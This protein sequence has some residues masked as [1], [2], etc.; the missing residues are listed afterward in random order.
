MSKLNI[1]K[2]H[3]DKSPVTSK[4]LAKLIDII[5]SGRISGKIAK[6]IFY[7]MYKTSVDP[8]TLIDKMNITQI[9]DK[10]IIITLCNEAIKEN[11]KAALEFQS[12]KLKA[13][14]SIV[15]IVMK[16]SKGKANPQLVIEVINEQLKKK[17]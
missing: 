5:I 7:E 11:I 9:S 3:I 8:I 10:S 17:K 15:G 16:K 12:G 1:S 2:L 13:I 14:D 4:N 6:Q